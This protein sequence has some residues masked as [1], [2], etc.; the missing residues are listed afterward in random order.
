MAQGKNIDSSNTLIPEANN[1][2]GQPVHMAE[3]QHSEH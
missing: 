2:F 1:K 3:I